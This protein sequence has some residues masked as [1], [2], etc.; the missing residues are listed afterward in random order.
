MSNGKPTREWL[1][2][3]RVKPDQNIDLS[4]YACDD[5]PP[6]LSETK[7]DKQLGKVLP[8]LT[9]LQYLL[10]ADAQRS[11]LVILQGRDAAG[12][13]GAI[14]HV[15]SGINPQGVR[16]TSFKQPT[17]QELA[18]DYLWRVH[19]AVP[20]K[21]EIAVFNRSHYEEV[22]VVRVHEMVP[23]PV[24]RSRYHQIREFEALLAASGTRILKFYLNL[25]PQEQLARFAKRLE[26]PA[27]H[28]KISESDYTER[29][30]WDEYTTAYQD[31][32]NETSSV[33]APWYVIPAD[34]KWV[35]NI[36]MAHIIKDTLEDMDL[37]APAVRVDLAEIRKHY[38]AAVAEAERQ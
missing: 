38:H 10:Y 22:L 4:R 15:F 30:R 11:L 33:A 19:K 17:P 24:W 34:H 28:W 25:S 16:V 6:G 2:S 9:R 12:K 5:I 23:E 32:L 36:A 13:D 7:A 35:R 21:G 1:D 26:D 27:R 14:R 31:M 18:H 3:L 20:G 29:K 8:D 37:Q